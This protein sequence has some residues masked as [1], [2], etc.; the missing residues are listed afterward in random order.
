MNMRITHPGQDS[1]P[2]HAF[3][4]ND[5]FGHTPRWSCCGSS[6][7]SY[8]CGRH[9]CGSKRSSYRFYAF[10]VNDDAYRQLYKLGVRA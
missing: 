9:R 7:G 4:I 3:N 10:N 8:S 5:A 2:F 6:C 1:Q